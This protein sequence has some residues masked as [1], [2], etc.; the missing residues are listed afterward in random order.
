MDARGGFFGSRPFFAALFSHGLVFFS[1]LFCV[2]LPLPLPFRL[3]LV[4]SR[5]SLLGDPF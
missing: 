4:E 5:G 3:I 1:L 2:M